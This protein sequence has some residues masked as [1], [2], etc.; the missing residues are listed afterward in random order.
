MNFEE[1]LQNLINDY[2]EQRTQLRTAIT[3]AETAEERTEILNATDEVEEQLRNAQEQLTNAQNEMQ[4]RS[5]P[6]QFNILN[7]Y[8][9]RGSNGEAENV[10]TDSVEYRTAF[11]NYVIAGTPIPGE[12]RANANT[13][14]SDVA[15]AIPTVLVNKI[16]ERM[17][18]CGMILPLVTKTNYQAGVV[19]PT[20]NVKPV[21]TWVSEGQGSDRQKKST[22]K[23]TFSY[24]KLRCEISMSMEAGTLALATFESK[25]IENVAKAM[26][27]AKEKAI[28]NGNGTTQPK[29]ILKETPFKTKELAKAEPTY[30]ELCEI[31]GLIPVEFEESAKWYMTKTTFMGIMGITDA[32]GQPIARVNYGISGKPERTILGRG[33]VCHPYAEEMGDTKAFIFDMSDYVLN[34][35]YD[36]GITKKQDWDTEDLLTKAVMS[37]DGKVI[38]TGSLITVTVKAAA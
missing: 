34:E 14:T 24:Y 19:V 23:I 17:E 1:Y 37:V 38:D 27:I 11:M 35:V 2:K 20:S 32:N 16:I 12:L 3:T 18:E 13:L 7:A 10:G 29:G 5:N 15:S 26:V 36:M 6:D 8:G 22:G 33:V 4:R 28:I 21:A 31:E 25:F 9:L 30:K